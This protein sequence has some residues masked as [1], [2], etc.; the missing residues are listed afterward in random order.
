MAAVFLLKSIYQQR[1]ILV[2]EYFEQ[3]VQPRAESDRRFT[4]RLGE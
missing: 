3:P 2:K 4:V 1:N